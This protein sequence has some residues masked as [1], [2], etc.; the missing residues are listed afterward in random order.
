MSYNIDPTRGYRQNNS[1]LDKA[2]AA[3]N[4]LVRDQYSTLPE[5]NKANS[6]HPL[7]KSNRSLS[8]D[9]ANT[10]SQSL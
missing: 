3:A 4:M 5:I 10:R 2:T 7:R 1:E 8:K 6:G 9:F